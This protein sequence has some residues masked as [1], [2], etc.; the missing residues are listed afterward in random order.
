LR[1][2]SSQYALLLY[3]NRFQLQELSPTKMALE[4]N[5]EQ[6]KLEAEGASTEQEATE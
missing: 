4:A 3:R 5:Y 6:A 1:V 2:A